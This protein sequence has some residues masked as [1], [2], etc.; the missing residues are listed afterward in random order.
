MIVF[1]IDTHIMKGIYVRTFAPMTESSWWNNDRLRV[2]I[3]VQHSSVQFSSDH[4][5]GKEKMH[6][7]VKRHRKCSFAPNTTVWIVEIVL[8]I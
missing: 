6:F 8:P 4:T 7:C 3:S 1:F 2:S 5:K